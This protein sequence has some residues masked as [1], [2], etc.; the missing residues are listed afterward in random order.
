M[1]ASAWRAR[2]MAAYSWQRQGEIISGL[3]PQQATQAPTGAGAR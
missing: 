2:R 1:P 3:D